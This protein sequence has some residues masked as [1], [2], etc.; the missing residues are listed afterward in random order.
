MLGSRND[1][2][3]IV[4]THGL[5]RTPEYTSWRAMWERCGNPAGVDY[6]RYGGRGITIC[7]RWKCVK[8]F[9]S[10]MGQ[11][12]G[13]GYSLERVDNSGPYTP[14]NCRWVTKDVQGQNRRSTRLNP[15]KVNEIRGRAEHGEPHWHI[16]QRFGVERST[17]TKVVARKSWA[18]L[19]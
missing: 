15:D 7:E 8:T 16:A 11:R 19:P 14:E 5:S 2:G 10:D 6:P 3:Q 13:K 9:V 18:R 4:A 1:K 12:P 17:V